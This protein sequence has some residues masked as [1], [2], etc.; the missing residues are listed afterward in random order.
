MIAGPLA[1]WAAG[2]WLHGFAYH[3]NPGIGIF[4]ATV[5]FTLI[6]ALIIVGYQS[7]KAAMANPVEALRYE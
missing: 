2:R 5:I 4:L 1:Y 6:I 3:F 7:V